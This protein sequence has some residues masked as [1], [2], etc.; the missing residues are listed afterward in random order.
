MKKNRNQSLAW[1]EKQ[2]NISI[3]VQI[4]NIDNPVKGIYGTF[5]WR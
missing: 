2:M 4:K 3:D 5:L 1:V